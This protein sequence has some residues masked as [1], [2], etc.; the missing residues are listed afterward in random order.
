MNLKSSKKREEEDSDYFTY[1]EDETDQLDTK[2]LQQDEEGVL[3][4]Q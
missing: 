4:M 3:L 2:L 1:E